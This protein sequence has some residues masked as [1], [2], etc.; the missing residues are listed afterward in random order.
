MGEK[1]NQ[2][3]HGVLSFAGQIKYVLEQIALSMI[4][5]PGHVRYNKVLDN[6]TAFCL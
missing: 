6:Q 5:I 1:S 4:S 3:L 2:L